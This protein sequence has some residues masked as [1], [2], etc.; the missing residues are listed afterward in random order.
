MNLKQEM[1]FFVLILQKLVPKT[2]K[3]K[4]VELRA[5]N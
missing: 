1:F 2:K 3:T 4:A 5:M